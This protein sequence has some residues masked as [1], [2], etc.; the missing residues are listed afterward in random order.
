MGIVACAGAVA[1]GR[2]AGRRG[3]L[4]CAGAGAEAGPDQSDRESQEPVLVRAVARLGEVAGSGGGAGILAGASDGADRVPPLSVA[5]SPGCVRGLLRPAGR[6]GVDFPC[7]V[8]ARLR[9]GVAQPEERLNMSK[10]DL[11]DEYR[12]TEGNPQVRGA[13][14]QPAAADAARTMRADIARASVVMTNPTHFAVALSFDFETMDAPRMLAKGRNLLA[15]QIKRRG[16]LGGGADR[17][18]SA[19]GALALPAGRGGT[20]HPVTS[21]MRRLPAFS[22][23]SIASRSRSGFARSRRRA[24]AATAAASAKCRPSFRRAADASSGRCRVLEAQLRTD[25]NPSVA[26]RAGSAS[27]GRGRRKRHEGA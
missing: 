14:S 20:G 6:R 13:D 25:G 26:R 18:E 11:R 27:N 5:R 9:G 3:H 16:A 2:G 15:E 21:C 23:S 17:R 10:Q 12:E 1:A 8:G 19:A 7:L 24:R 4:S 22:R